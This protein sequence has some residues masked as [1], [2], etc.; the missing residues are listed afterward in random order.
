[1]KD[2]LKFSIQAKKDL[3][4]IESNI[5]D[6]SYVQIF[7]NRLSTN[8]CTLQ[9]ENKLDYNQLHTIKFNEKTIPNISIIKLEIIIKKNQHPNILDME[10]ISIQVQ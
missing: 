6:N 8:L 5:P 1:M 9:R 10:V 7:Y 2:Q 4:L 3:Q